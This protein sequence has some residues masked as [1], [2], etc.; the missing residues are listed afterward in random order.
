MRKANPILGPGFLKPTRD[1]EVGGNDNI[2]SI[3]HI[4]DDGGKC[5]GISEMI[6]SMSPQLK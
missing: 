1:I 4:E 6:M 3:T 2:A 5:L